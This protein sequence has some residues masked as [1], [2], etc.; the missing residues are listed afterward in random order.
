MEEQVCFFDDSNQTDESETSAIPTFCDAASDQMNDYFIDLVED[1]I[2]NIS[3]PE[4][5]Y[6]I[7]TLINEKQVLIVM[8][9]IYLRKPQSERQSNWLLQHLAVFY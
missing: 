4:R 5:S 7:N 2:K 9:R 1:P 6:F 8:V 3:S